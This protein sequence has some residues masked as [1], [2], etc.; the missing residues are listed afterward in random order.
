MGN[1]GVNGY[2]T[3]DGTKNG[4]M[5]YDQYVTIEMCLLEKK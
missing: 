3:D 1:G 5:I 2:N 4:A